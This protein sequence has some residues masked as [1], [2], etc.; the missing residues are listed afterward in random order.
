MFA[1]VDI[2]TT[3]GS[4]RADKITEVSIF[5]HDGLRIIDEFTTL[6]NPERNISHFITQLTGINNEMVADAPKFYEVAKKI[7]EITDKQIFVAHSASFDYNFIRNEFKSIGFEYNRKTLCTVSLSRKVFPGKASYSL[8]KICEN[9]HIKITDRHRARGDALATVKLL[10]ILLNNDKN[11]NAIKIIKPE[12]PL[13]LNSNLSRTKLEKIPEKTGV[14]F[15]YDKK[16]E[17]LYIG[18]SK[19]IR[20]RVMQ[21]LNNNSTKRAMEMREKISDI[22]F[23]L[24]GNELIALLKESDLIKHHKPPNNRAQRRT[25]YNYSLLH[26][27]NDSG[28]ICFRFEHINNNNEPLTTY[29][30]LKSGKEEMERLVEEF[31]LCQKLS[32]LYNSNG[33][34][35]HHGIGECK[36]ACIGE[37]DV[38]EYN[39]RAAELINKFDF[40][41]KN[42]LII[43]QGRK[44]GENSVVHIKNGKYLGCG[45]VEAE[46]TGNNVSNL[47]DS[48]VSYEENRDIRSIIKSYIRRNNV[49]KIELDQH[50][51][52]MI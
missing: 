31:G 21:H 24:C 34:C 37:E 4:P 17:L 9:L 50:D 2:E 46:F 22:D 7:V 41:L 52:P 29:T 3:G 6:I 15:F 11:K 20:S 8:G 48:I 44:S 45:F 36:G 12:F 51:I 19:N 1:I 38:D 16:G 32:G 27:K 28:Y 40:H 14:Y 25:Y 10:E 30:S 23:E 35:F 18:K 5:I 33:A 49:L 42:F 26:E 13:G 43:G 39:K 47:I